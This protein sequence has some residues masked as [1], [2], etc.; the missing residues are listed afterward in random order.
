MLKAEI[1]REIRRMQK[2]LQDCRSKKKKAESEQRELNIIISKI[3]Q[4]TEEIEGG[5]QETLRTIEKRLGK[6]NPKSKFKV[7]Y[8]EKAKGFLQN[9]SSSS[10]VENSRDAERKAKKKYLELDDTISSYNSKI[11]SLEQD[12]E[13]LNNQLKQMGA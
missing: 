2:Q 12:I 5:L 11:R 4:K 8:L 6:L 7:K 1:E 13:K 9:S 10:A 3:R